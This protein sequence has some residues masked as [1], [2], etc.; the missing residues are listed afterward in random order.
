MLALLAFGTVCIR[1]QEDSAAVSEKLM[2]K[3]ARGSVRARS[4]QNLKRPLAGSTKQT[5]SCIVFLSSLEVVCLKHSPELWR[6][7]C[8]SDQMRQDEG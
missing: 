3:P 4:T 8:S 1:L 5:S 7:C 6:C 2:V